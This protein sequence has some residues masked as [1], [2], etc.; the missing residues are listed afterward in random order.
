LFENR[1]D[2]WQHEVRS[3]RLEWF[4]NTGKH[5]TFQQASAFITHMKDH[6]RQ[7][8]QDS[9]LPALKHIFHHPTLSQEGVC[10]LCGNSTTKLK[11]HIAKHLQQLALFAIPQ[12]DY[13]D[14]SDTED[15]QS[16][17]ALRSRGAPVDYSLPSTAASS[18]PA[19]LQDLGAPATISQSPVMSNVDDPFS[20]DELDLMSRG[21]LGS[22]RVFGLSP[23]YDSIAS[24]KA[25]QEGTPTATETPKEPPAVSIVIDEGEDTSWDFVTPK[26]REARAA[27]YD[28]R[29][30]DVVKGRPDSPEKVSNAHNGMQNMENY[31]ADIV[32]MNPYHQQRPM[33]GA[34]I[35]AY[36]GEHLP[37]VSLGGIILVDGEPFGL[38]VHH[39]LDAP[40]DDE[41]DGEPETQDESTALDLP[42]VGGKDEEAER[43]KDDPE[44][45]AEKLTVKSSQAQ[46]P[47]KEIETKEHTT[48]NNPWLAGQPSGSSDTMRDP[49]L[50]DGASGEDSDGDADAFDFS[51][52]EFATDDEAVT[53]GPEWSGTTPGDIPGIHLGQGEHIKITQPAIDDVDE[54]FFLTKEDRD[55]EHLLSHKFGHV[56]ASSGI[57]RWKRRGI[58]HEIDWALI[59]I[60]PDRLQPWNIVQGGRRFRSGK[61][62]NPPPTKEPV[63]RRHYTPEEDEYP[64]E[65]ADADSLG[66]LNVHCFGRTTGL[67]G[68]KIGPA[69]VS[70]RMYHRETFSRSWFVTGG[71]KICP[72]NLKFK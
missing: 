58:L 56:Y 1:E 27:M 41:S 20:N 25:L 60:D 5:Q 23:S 28:T 37:P 52:S 21:K 16:D 42:N 43:P 45:Q 26:F 2:W 70:V 15:A 12:T 71:C 6:H 4:C 8:I 3:H 35:G 63:D 64:M 53:P 18:S 51:D 59:K 9:Q 29:A 10:N 54:D 33:C 50:S 22:D 49:E 17:M 34:S 57:R 44:S 36:R 65:V 40:S 19:Q 48:R 61:E 11:S 66:E 30:P 31:N 72:A 7:V 62:L 14:E 47:Y 69:M 38:T 13:M 46:E 24:F 39:L 32:V 55:K 68:G 67:Q